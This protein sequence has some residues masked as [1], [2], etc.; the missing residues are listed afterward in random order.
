MVRKAPKKSSLAA[1]GDVA[2][3]VVAQAPAAPP[4]PTPKRYP[5]KVSFYQDPLDTD[6]MRGAVLHTM[7]R[8]GFRSQSDFIQRAVMREVERLE[9]LHNGG[10]PFPSVE[11]G[12]MP[13]GR[14]LGG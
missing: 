7:A 6:R 10:K 11:A 9:Q 4:V 3:P 13:K 2:Q 12:E 8:E 14:P 5:H 1:A